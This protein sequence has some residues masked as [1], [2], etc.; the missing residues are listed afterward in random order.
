MTRRTTTL[1]ATLL[2]LSPVAARADGYPAALAKAEQALKANPGAPALAEACRVA[3]SAQR[4]DIAWLVKE[5]RVAQV[6]AW[7]DAASLAAGK[8]GP[9]VQLVDS[10]EFS[11]PEPERQARAEV[12]MRALYGV[13]LKIVRDPAKNQISIDYGEIDAAKLESIIAEYWVPNQ[14]WGGSSGLKKGQNALVL[15]APMDKEA[16]CEIL[17]AKTKDRAAGIEWCRVE[18]LKEGAS[19]LVAFRGKAVAYTGETSDAGLKPDEVVLVGR[20]DGHWEIA[21]TVAGAAPVDDQVHVARLRSMIGNWSSLRTHREVAGLL[22]H[23]D[24]AAKE[25]Q[26]GYTAE[27]NKRVKQRP[28]VAFAGASFDSWTYPA[29]PAAGATCDRVFFKAYAPKKDSGF[30]LVLKVDG[31]ECHERS[32]SA[33]NV[34]PDADSLTKPTYSHERSDCPNPLAA[35]GKHEV[36]SEIY[37]LKAGVVGQEVRNGVVQDRWMSGLDKKLGTW[38]VTCVT[39]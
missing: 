22:A 11:R 34:P 3:A 14:R 37:S 33:D 21:M 18:A 4:T 30:A 39:P 26:G 12:A 19:A 15:L 8:R 38:K 20:A 10:I 13:G 32:I 23:A 1:L 24:K 9:E 2:S 28:F 35:P 31:K 25:K 36:T 16:L 17:A 7:C 5:A 29:P 27:E 6:L